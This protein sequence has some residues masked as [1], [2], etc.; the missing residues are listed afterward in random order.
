ML[1]HSGQS[2]AHWLSNVQR[3][4]NSP[5]I[6]ILH[7]VSGKLLLGESCESLSNELDESDRQR[8]FS[9]FK[10]HLGKKTKSSHSPQITVF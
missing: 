10:S 7:L 2:V 5:L 9:H 6:L 8:W 4:S 1:E 3:E